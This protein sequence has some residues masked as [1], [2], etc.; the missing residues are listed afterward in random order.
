MRVLMLTELYPP[1]IGGSEEYVR[2]LARGLVERGHEVSVVTIS[3]DGTTSD[4]QD[5]GLLVHRVRSS[6]QR[7]SALMPS[8]RPYLPPAPDPDLV[9]ALRRIVAEERPDV[10]HA[11]NWAV[12]S[13]LPLK[14]ADG[15]RLV[16]TLHDYS[17]VCA[18]RSLLYHGRDC[19][20]PGFS[21]CLH[22]AAT[23]YG[24]ARGELITIGTWLSSPLV[25][26]AVD[27]FIPVSTAVATRSGLATSGTAFEVVPNFVP[28][29]VVNTASA[30]HPGLAALPGG[31]YWLYVGALSRHKG[32]STLLDAYS[33]INAI[34]GA[35]PLV[36]VGR[37]TGEPVPPMPAG[38]T[39]ISDLP[40][41]AVMAAWQRAT[42]GIIPSHF[43]DPCPTVAL[44]AMACGVPVV[45][46]HIGGLVDLVVDGETGVL[47]EAGD[48][49][50]LR[51]GL[52][53]ILD[54]E[55]ERK[56]M[57]RAG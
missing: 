20:G 18:K 41:D 45:G 50:A 47:V 14:R 6:T 38:V 2:N 40:H 26:R 36:V 5:G 13:F 24:T 9:A 23:N 29:D 21:K 49:A 1:F 25:V 32:I 51:A 12:A 17:L 54:N 33:A 27:E 56:R 15:P 28:D 57:A 3:A 52:C 16:M 43:P 4:E 48:A 10:I 31:G 55:Q 11:H 30:D 46:S 39:L 22:C 42:L 44:E 34:K 35:P 37:T 7:V 53:R 19:S 8:G